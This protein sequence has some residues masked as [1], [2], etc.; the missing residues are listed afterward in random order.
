MNERFGD[1]DLGPVLLNGRGVQTISIR[2][3]DIDTERIL[4]VGVT[5]GKG[6]I[7]GARA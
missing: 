3:C 7:V 5:V 2:S 4:M 1:V 6:T